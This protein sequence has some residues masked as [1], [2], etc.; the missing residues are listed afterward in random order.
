MSSYT[1]KIYH[2]DKNLAKNKEKREIDIIPILDKIH[3]MC[4]NSTTYS[5]IL[6]TVKS[7]NLAQ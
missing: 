6:S 5:K 7:Q 1:D 4:K 2:V 3:G